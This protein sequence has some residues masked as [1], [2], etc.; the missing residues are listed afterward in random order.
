MKQITL[1]KNEHISLANTSPL[2]SSL[3]QVLFQRDSIAL[4]YNSSQVG[5][6]FDEYFVPQQRDPGIQMVLCQCRSIEEKFPSVTLTLSYITIIDHPKVSSKS[7][8]A[9]SIDF[10]IIL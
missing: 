7:N 3:A 6:S 2:L 1:F 9:S 5:G 8:F 4:I 10:R